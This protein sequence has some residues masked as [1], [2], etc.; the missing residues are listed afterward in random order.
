MNLATKTAL[1]TGASGGIGAATAVALA[2]QGCAVAIHF[3]SNA[4]AAAQVL[5]DCDSYSQGNFVISADLSN[6]GEVRSLLEDV[7]KKFPHLDILVNNAGVFDEN[8][9]PGNIEAFENIYKNNFLSSVLVTKYALPL[10]PAGKIINVSSIHGRLGYGSPEAIAYSAGKAALESY[11]KNLAKQLAPNI[12][13][14]AVAPGRVLTPMWGDPDEKE[15]KELG[16][17]QLIQRMI[18]PEEIA[19]AIVFLAKNDAMC[20]EIL[21][22]DGGYGLVSLN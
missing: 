22:I 19:D 20:G 14:N 6:E 13:V 16:S 12:L 3:K 21:T 11:T 7:G 2:Q 4:V 18:R 17:A 1:V 5:R 15:Q 10:M 9:G 8:D